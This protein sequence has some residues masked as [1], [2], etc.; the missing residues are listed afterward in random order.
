MQSYKTDEL[1]E[2]ELEED[3]LDIKLE[4]EL[5]ITKILH[6]LDIKLEDELEED[7]LDIKLEDEL[8]ITK[9]LVA[10]AEEKIKDIVAQIE[11]VQSENYTLK[12]QIKN[13]VQIAIKRRSSGQSSAHGSRHRRMLGYRF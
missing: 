13:M 7:E 3:K 11:Q 1:E 4:D 5:R 8:R 9:I 2:D 6:E 10:E 12:K